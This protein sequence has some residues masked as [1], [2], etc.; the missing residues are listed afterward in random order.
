M[1]YA[2]GGTTVKS[3]LSLP[4]APVAKKHFWSYVANRLVSLPVCNRIRKN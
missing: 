2:Y 4:F 1:T 3:G